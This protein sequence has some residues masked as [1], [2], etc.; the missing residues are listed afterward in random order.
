MKFR[1]TDGWGR[2]SGLVNLK[3]RLRGRGDRRLA[4]GH[5]R[6]LLL[7]LWLLAGWLSA[8]D[9]PILVIDP[10]GHQAKIWDVMFTRDGKYLVSASDDKTVRVWDVETGE[11][12]RVLRGQIGPGGEGKLYAAALSPGL[13]GR[14]EGL[15]A[16]GGFLGSFTGKKPREEEGAHQI[17]LMDFRTGEVVGLLKGHTN[18]IL[19]LAF[20]PDGKM[21][22]SGSFD[23]TARVWDV[24]RSGERGAGSEER[25]ARSGERGQEG[26]KMRCRAEG[27]YGLYLRGGV[28]AGRQTR[29]HRPR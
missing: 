25:G 28:L 24:G 12:V 23:E 27:A 17:R 6:T 1:R 19:G 26:R 20:S 4:A 10:G 8:G 3:A 16:V 11:T 13:P 7:G 14:P 29:G 9:E 5:W 18:V 21:L 15:L 22:I 2:R